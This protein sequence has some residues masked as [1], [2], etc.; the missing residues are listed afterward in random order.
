[1]NG[2]PDSASATPAPASAAPHPPKTT[3]ASAGSR[4]QSAREPKP[5]RRADEP[6][7][8]TD[9]PAEQHP[10]PHPHPPAQNG[11]RARAPRTAKARHSDG[12]AAARGRGHA[13]NGV[14][15][16]GHAPPG[17]PVA[18]LAPEYASVPNGVAEAGSEELWPPALPS[19]PHGAHPFVGGPGVP[20]VRNG[21]TENPGRTIYSQHRQPNR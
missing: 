21:L 6:P 14:G 13:V 11:G 3:S 15:A 1:M 20:F 4:R 17:P 10:H 8:D 18:Y 2:T 5:R 9:S 16:N 19:P 12:P 7:R